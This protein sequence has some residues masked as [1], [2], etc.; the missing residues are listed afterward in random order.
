MG[1][2]P[3]R[4]A[5]LPPRA[6]WAPRH[7]PTWIGVGLLSLLQLLPVAVRD[8]I[9]AGVGELQYRLSGRRRRTVELNLELC[10]PQLSAV[11]RAARARAHFHAWARSMADQPALWW[12]FHCRVP[13]RRCRIHGL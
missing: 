12:D 9:A 10:F 4:R 8:A 1:K 5:G 11:E 3:D 6:L 7:W 2:G 13:E